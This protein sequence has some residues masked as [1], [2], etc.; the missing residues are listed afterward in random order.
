MFMI[1]FLNV[2]ITCLPCAGQFL[3]RDELFE[4]LALQVCFPES[5]FKDRTPPSQKPSKI[6]ETILFRAPHALAM[7][8]Y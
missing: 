2:I 6:C 5:Y 3:Q 7:Q 8:I 1:T 4:G